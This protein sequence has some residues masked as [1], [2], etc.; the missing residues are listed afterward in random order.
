ML[1]VTSHATITGID[2]EIA[3][4]R[5]AQ[6][7]AA[8]EPGVMAVVPFIESRGL[9]ANGAARGRR[10]WC[11]ASCRKKRAGGGPGI[12]SQVAAR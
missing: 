8:R 4:W 7:D 11:A 5:Q 6:T 1:S 3:D 2:G 10:A 9:L 12:A